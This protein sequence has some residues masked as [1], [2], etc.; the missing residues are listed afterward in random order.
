MQKTDIAALHKQLKARKGA[1]KAVAEIANVKFI[2]ASRTFN[3]K[4]DK[5]N[6]EVIKAGMEY[7][8][9]MRA[10][11]KRLHELVTIKTQD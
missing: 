10:E 3:G 5:P 4:V 8:Q 11:D 6:A 2:T 1:I 7:L 9:R